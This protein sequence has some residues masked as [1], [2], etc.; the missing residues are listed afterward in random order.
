MTANGGEAAPDAPLWKG[1]E[2]ERGASDPGRP[3]GY[4]RGMEEQ[5][6]TALSPVLEGP[7]H[8]AG[9]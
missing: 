4:V 2:G 8:R 1:H 6:L 9:R 7:V 5:G 3:G